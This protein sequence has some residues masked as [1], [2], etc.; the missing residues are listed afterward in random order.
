MI[1]Y[2]DLLPDR[3]IAFNR[4]FVNLGI[5][6]TGA[7]FL[8]QAVYWHKR[9]KNNDKWFY[10]VFEEWQEEIGLTRREFETARER[11]KAKGYIEEQKKGIPA[12]L[13]YRICPDKIV[14][15]LQASMLQ[16]SMLQ[17]SMSESCILECENDT[18]CN[19]QTVQPVVSESC[20]IYT[21]ITQE[22]TKD[23]TSD[24]TTIK[25]QKKTTESEN[26]LLISKE[27]VG[28]L[29]SKLGTHYKHT[30]VE[31]IKKIK[32]RL[33]EGFTVD[34]FKTVIDKKVLLWKNDIKMSA[35]LRPE[36]LFGTKFESYLNEIVSSAKVM[37]ANGVLGEKTARGFNAVQE[38]LN[39]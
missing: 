10:K 12:K 22:N 23:T 17:T 1:N 20:I 38:F 6:I 27:I 26:I 2:N 25:K 32:A 11:L 30:S 34:D 14:Q 36:T 29:N 8:S 9:T 16:T 21:D 31:T 7:L 18:N 24:I 4:D 28:Y 19:A 39:D 37:S 3:P 35:Y 5:G 33:K 13:Y 15:D